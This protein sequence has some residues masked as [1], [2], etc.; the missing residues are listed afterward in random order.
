MTVLSVCDKYRTVLTEILPY[1]VP[2]LFSNYGFYGVLKSDSQR[3]IFEKQFDTIVSGKAG[4]YIPFNY[5]IRKYTSGKSRLLSIIHPK[6]QL[7]VVE[8]YEKNAKYLL[9]LCNRSPLSIRYINNIS[10][11]TF[12]KTDNKVPDDVDEYEEMQIVKC[13]RNYFNYEKFDFLYKFFDSIDFTHLESKY[14]YCMTLDIAK[15]FYHIYTHSISWSVKGKIYSKAY[16]RSESLE[17][18]FD[19]LMQHCNYNETNGIVVGPEM[20]RIFSEIILQDID[21]KI[22]RDLKN[23]GFTLGKDYDIRRYVDDSFVFFNDY[24]CADK[25]KKIMKNVMKTINYM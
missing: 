20:S 12:E 21:L 14:K 6:E 18:S 5:R 2:L 22:I 4:W 10:K 8:F 1:E 9:Y 23:D 15:C 7:E 17:N 24:N 16:Q 25:I 11:C 13:F 3:A 19:K